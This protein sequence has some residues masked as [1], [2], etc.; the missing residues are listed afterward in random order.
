VIIRIRGLT[1]NRRYGIAIHESNNVRNQC[2][3]VGAIFNPENRR[4]PTGALATL[5]ADRNGNI[6]ATLNNIA[7]TI[8]G[9]KRQSIVDRSCVIRKPRDIRSE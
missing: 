2:R 5:N 1:P 7:L 3:N 6:S 4:P 9:S 8:T